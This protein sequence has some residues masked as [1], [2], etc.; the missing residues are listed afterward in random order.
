MWVL[1]LSL[2]LSNLSM[3][4]NGTLTSI[5]IKTLFLGTCLSVRS[6]FQTPGLQVGV[7]TGKD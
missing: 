6:G 1:D 3:K 5:W 7:T 4:V 2:P